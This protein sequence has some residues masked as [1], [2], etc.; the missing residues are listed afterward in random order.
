MLKTINEK[1]RVT[2]VYSEKMMPTIIA[3]VGV[4]GLGAGI[5][6][7]GTVTLYTLLALLL[8]PSVAFLAA[9]VMFKQKQILLIDGSRDTVEEHLGKKRIVF[10]F[11]EIEYADVERVR[12]DEEHQAEPV[13]TEQEAVQEE[14]DAAIS[15]ETP[16]EHHQ[17]VER[18]HTKTTKLHLNY[19]PYLKLKNENEK[20]FFF[21]NK[22]RGLAKHKSARVVVE[23]V[24]KYIGVAKLTTENLNLYKIE[25]RNSSGVF[26]LLLILILLAAAAYLVI[27]SQL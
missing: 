12:E 26:A 16:K 25:K 2:F 14:H 6:V 7:I 19:H 4:L 18:T 22:G 10:K 24:N 27:Q 5:S 17:D 8:G 15:Q 21:D 13:K 23:E 1:D 11:S 3:S 20:Y 9:Y